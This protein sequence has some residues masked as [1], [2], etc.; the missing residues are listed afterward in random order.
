[1]HCVGCWRRHLV[2]NW[3]HQQVK[4]GYFS[5]WLCYSMEHPTDVLAYT[6][7]LMWRPSCMSPVVLW[8]AA[9]VEQAVYLT[10]GR[11]AGEGIKG[12]YA[13]V[14]EGQGGGNQMKRKENIAGFCA[15][16]LCGEQ[17]SEV[18]GEWSWENCACKMLVSTG[19]HNRQC[20][21]LSEI[22]HWRQ[23]KG[24]QGETGTELRHE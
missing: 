10:G 16:L 22:L 2:S 14:W 11:I 7:R 6:G 3:T 1:M 23:C 15:C 13:C 5:I 18:K 21:R 19:V 24:T 12:R 20:W 4:Q 17:L 8:S 9:L